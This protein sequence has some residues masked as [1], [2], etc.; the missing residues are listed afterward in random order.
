M[1]SQ[2]FNDAKRFIIPPNRH[3][4]VA[5]G[6]RS[7]K[8]YFVEHY[9]L[10][11][12]NV[13]KLDTKR[14]AFERK[15]QGKSAWDGLEE[16][17]DFTVIE[18]LAD[19]VNIETPKIIYAPVPEEQE[20]N[21]YEEFFRFIFERENTIVWADETMSFTTATKF[22]QRFKNLLIMGASKNI[23]VWCCTQRP[24]GIP[25]IIGA[26][27][28]Y[29]IIFNLNQLQDRK[30]LVEI[31]GC[32]EFLES[33]SDHYEDHQFYF[34]RVGDERPVKMVSVT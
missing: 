31:S 27:V 6:T 2:Q 5:G 34:Y 1:N 12:Q 20:M 8:S 13:I 33:P 11:Y 19:I 24:L 28:S 9:L 3:V 32:D 15:R 7:G 14:E 22:P 29:L 18:H 25:S 17:K 21:Y 16:G 26:N 4:M 10:M 30:R 23:G